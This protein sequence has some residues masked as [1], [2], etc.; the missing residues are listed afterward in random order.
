MKSRSIILILVVVGVVVIGGIVYYFVSNG[1][2]QTAI[3][4]STN[5]TSGSGLVS[6]N[7]GAATGIPSA[8][9]SSSGN[10]TG[11]QVVS[12]LRNLSVINLSNAVFTNPA[13]PQLQDISIQIPPAIDQGRRNPF[14]AVG[15]DGTPSITPTV[16]Q[17]TNSSSNGGGPTTGN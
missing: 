14:A 3:S 2:T 7:T 6:T 11:A 15:S 9:P 17:S 12:I 4:P 1:T 5:S 13:F 8:T 16:T 10:S